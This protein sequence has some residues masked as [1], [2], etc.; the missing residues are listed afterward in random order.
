M[1]FETLLTN[2]KSFEGFRDRAYYDSGGT[3]T[4]GYGRTGNISINATTT[5]EYEDD[6]LEC[7]V[8]E[9]YLAVKT[10]MNLTH[11]YNLSENQLYALT[12][13]C[14]NLGL[15]RLDTLTANYLRSINEIANAIL[16]YNK[17]KGTVLNG[18]T[19]RRRW[20]YD[21]FTSDVAS[22]QQT[23][24]PTEKTVQQLV[25]E[26]IK[27]KGY[28]IEFLLVDGKIGRKSL[29]ALTNI[30]QGVIEDGH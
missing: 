5:R 8:R 9:L 13:F 21:L 27:K 4:I 2:I 18:L 28:A 23:E 19:K 22:T 29:L 17:C 20:E 3:I 7:K 1:T 16:L 30:L 11:N 14:Y 25:N 10:K 26:V 12:D 15:G 24:T 6:W